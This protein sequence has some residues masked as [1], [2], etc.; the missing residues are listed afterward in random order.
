MNEHLITVEELEAAIET[1]K[2]WTLQ[3]EDHRCCIVM[4]GDNREGK[5][6]LECYMGPSEAIEASFLHHFSNTPVALEM[7]VSITSLVLRL[8]LQ[9]VDNISKK[10]ARR[11]DA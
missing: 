4:A 2:E 8:G 7:F 3:G 11:C 9:E 6:S 5:Q 10:L 1:V